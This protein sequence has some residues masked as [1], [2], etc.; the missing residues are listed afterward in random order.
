VNVSNTTL[1]GYS[2]AS[3]LGALGALAGVH[4]GGSDTAIQTLA[5][6]VRIGPEGIRADGINVVAPGLGTV[7][8][9]GTISSSNALNFKMN[10]KVEGGGG[11]AGG[12][13]QITSLGGSQGNVPFLIQGTTSAPVFVP[14]V[15]G[16]VTN[17]ASPEG[18]SG[19]LGGIFGKK[20][21][22]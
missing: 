7:T 8:G 16:A 20:K 6:S 21:N 9:A 14:D 18:V 11:A 19:I 10:A 2:V 22:K 3:K 5:S 15:A 17:V 4:G 12:L 1:K 13:S